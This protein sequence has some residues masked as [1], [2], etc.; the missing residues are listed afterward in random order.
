MPDFLDAVAAN[1]IKQLRP[2]MTDDQA[3]HIGKHFSK[4]DAAVL[5]ALCDDEGE[6]LPE[7]LAAV[8]DVLRCG[9]SAIDTMNYSTC[10]HDDPFDAARAV[11]R[12]LAG[13]DEE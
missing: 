3:A 7:V 12:R 13:R 9:C 1:R 8:I 4:V 2:S 5:A 10:P 6:P 11:I